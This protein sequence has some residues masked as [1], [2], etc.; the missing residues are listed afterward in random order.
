[1]TMDRMHISVW[2]DDDNDTRKSEDPM[3]D[4]DYDFSELY[5]EDDECQSPAG[6]GEASANAS[7]SADGK[8][9][10]HRTILGS[11]FDLADGP[12]MFELMSPILATTLQMMPISGEARGAA[13]TLLDEVTGA[14]RQGR[15]KRRAE[16]EAL[17]QEQ[18][19]QEMRDDAVAAGVRQRR[20]AE[21][22]ADELAERRAAARSRKH[23]LEVQDALRRGA[24]AEAILEAQENAHWVEKTIVKAAREQA[25][26]LQ[27]AITVA[28]ELGAPRRAIEASLQLHFA[29]QALATSKLATDFLQSALEIG[30]TSQLVVERKRTKR[31][32]GKSHGPVA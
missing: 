26:T 5:L 25:R 11:S 27:S 20:R 15:H 6:P 21:W 18:L 8:A 14:V 9:G 17:A 31:T 7:N 23:E 4:R 16:A 29:E 30:C 24:A 1:M 19:D 10:H 12:S 22:E 13:T 28:E 32:K 2:E 3:P